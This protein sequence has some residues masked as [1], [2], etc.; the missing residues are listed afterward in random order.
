[1]GECFFAERSS[2]ATQRTFILVRLS[3][4][5]LDDLFA[6][7]QTSAPLATPLD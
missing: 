7:E 3:K 4:T 5:Q 6:P 1:L 2:G